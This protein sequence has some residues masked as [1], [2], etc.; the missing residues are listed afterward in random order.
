VILYEAM[1]AAL[2]LLICL[3]R[4]KIDALVITHQM[5]N[6]VSM[7]FAAFGISLYVAFIH[8]HEMS[9]NTTFRANTL[10]LGIRHKHLFLLWMK[11]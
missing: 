6:F 4:D 9:F 8:G 1:V 7:H 2:A 11:K 5:F 10:D 3:D